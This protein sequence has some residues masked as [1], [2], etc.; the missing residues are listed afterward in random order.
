M[1]PLSSYVI[2]TAVTLAGLGALA[3]LLVFAARRSGMSKPTGSLE[4]VGR[5]SLDPRRAVY[6][7]RI[8]GKTYILG[9]SEAGLVNLGIVEQPGPPE[10]TDVR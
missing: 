7:V 9:G 1:S 10:P 6:L 3:A 5:L 2:Q 8:A 4:V